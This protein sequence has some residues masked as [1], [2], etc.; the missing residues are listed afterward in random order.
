MTQ[1]TEREKAIQQM[2]EILGNIDLDNL[3][4]K[5]I[6]EAIL[7]ASYRKQPL[8]IKPLEFHK[9]S[10]YWI[11]HPFQGVSWV[12][13]VI[14]EDFEIRYCEN[15]IGRA[16][17][18]EGAL[19]I[20]NTHHRELVGKCLV[21][22]D[23]VLPSDEELDRLVRSVRA[24]DDLEA[25]VV[26]ADLSKQIKS[27]VEKVKSA[28]A[29]PVTEGKVW[30]DDKD[31]LEWAAKAGHVKCAGSDQWY[32]ISDEMANNGVAQYYYPTSNLR[33]EYQR[34][35]ESLKK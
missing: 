6:A 18:L 2:V 23:S 3:R 32:H 16:Y 25:D 20:A 35:L 33:T 1:Q 4:L 14:D 26:I 8:A 29:A 17:S 28:R 27:I 7:D 22:G 12:N 15:I 19:E 21:P 34:H 31:F 13:Y 10:K 9:R 5:Q 11:A 30:S 24:A